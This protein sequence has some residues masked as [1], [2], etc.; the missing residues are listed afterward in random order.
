[1]RDRWVVAAETSLIASVGYVAAVHPRRPDHHWVC[2]LS[3][4]P[5]A[6]SDETAA[7]CNDPFLADGLMGLC[8]HIRRPMGLPC[9]ELLSVWRL[10]RT[11]KC[12]S[13]GRLQTHIVAV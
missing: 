7:H 11:Y 5:W 3:T 12:G 2:F 1:M 8:V 6:L 4:L 10:T 9:G 13:T